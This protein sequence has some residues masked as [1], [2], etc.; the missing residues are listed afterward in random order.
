MPD[1]EV[2][3]GYSRFL[4]RGKIKSNDTALEM[5]KIVPIYK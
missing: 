2:R 1:Y 5:S 4:D 3:N